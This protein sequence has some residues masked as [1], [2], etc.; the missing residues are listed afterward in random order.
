MFVFTLP[1]RETL[2]LIV[3][4]PVIIIVPSIVTLPAMLTKPETPR[5]P[6]TATSPNMN[7]P[8]EF[9]AMLPE[10]IDIE[11]F[12]SDEP[13]IRMRPRAFMTPLSL[14]TPLMSEVP[15]DES[16]PEMTLIPLRD[17]EPLM[18]V[19]PSSTRRL[20]DPLPTST[21]KP[22]EDALIDASV[23]DNE[24]T[25]EAFEITMR[26]SKLK[27]PAEAP[28]LRTPET[29]T[30]P[31]ILKLPLIDE[32]RTLP[33]PSPTLTP[34]LK[35][36]RLTVDR[37][38]E[39]LKATLD[40]CSEP[41][42]VMLPD[43]RLTTV[44][45][46]MLRL[47]VMLSKPLREVMLTLLPAPKPT[48]VS[49]LST[50]RLTPCR[51][52]EPDK[53]APDNCSEPSSVM[54][55]DG[56]LTTVLPSMLR[57]PVMLSK[58]LR[59]VMLTL[60]PAPKPTLVSTLSTLRL[61]PC[62]LSEPD[63]LAPD[64]CSEPSSVMLPDGRLTTVLPSMLRLPVMLSKPLRE[65]MLTLLPAP[66]PTILIPIHDTQM[67]TSF[68]LTEP[69]KLA[70]DNCSEPSSVMLPDGRATTILPS[71]LRLPVMLSAPSIRLA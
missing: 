33:E 10:P 66:K 2:P 20:S 23:S 49:T 15:E 41:S 36:L 28:R 42:S 65:V 32:T 14:E 55:P 61:T 29:S 27:P 54:L 56:R 45:P 3:E 11:P 67:I 37:L 30:L 18:L 50:L 25:T 60:L 5:L 71:M 40:N 31:L 35:T 48:L 12:I 53:L 51:L 22:L 7:M 70:P 52:S 57:L 19:K 9:K 1:E 64:N 17:T 24:P 68:S 46:S 26:P 69:D 38:A 58:P 62:R 39:A 63:K 43:G 47:P 16:E 6:E 4:V 34:S 21:T 59:E 44:L 8:E 13:F